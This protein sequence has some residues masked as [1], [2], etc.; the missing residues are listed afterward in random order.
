MKSLILALCLCLTGLLSAHHRYDAKI[1]VHSTID[2]GPCD[3]D[4]AERNVLIERKTVNGLEKIGLFTGSGCQFD[5]KT[6]LEAGDYVITFTGLAFET[7]QIDFI[8]N[9]TNYKHLV[10]GTVLLLSKTTQLNEVT[11][12]GNRRQFVKVESD[13]TTI[14]VRENG[15][16]NSGSSLDAVKKLPG[17]IKAPGGALSLNGK[18]VRIYID[19]SPSSLS[20]TDLENY[21][22]TLPANAIEKVELIYNPG[23]AYDANS[24]GSIINIVT[25]SKRM[26]GIN[27]SFNINYN[28]NRYQKPSPQ[29]LLNGREKDL[30]WQTMIGYN[31]IEGRNQNNTLQEFTYFTPVQVLDQRNLALFHWRNFYWRSGLNYKLNERSNLLLNYNLSTANDHIENQSSAFGPGVAYENNSM[32]KAK[33]AI[34]EVVL[35]YKVKLD[36]I[37][38][39]LDVTGF[40]NFFKRNPKSQATSLDNGDDTYNNSDID[41]RLENHYLKYDLAIPFRKIDFSIST[42][43]KYNILKVSNFGRYNFESDTDAIFGS[44]DF[45]DEIDFD[46]TEKNL[47]FY[48]EARKKFGKL[49]MTAGLRFEDFRV[50]RLASTVADRIEFNNTNFFPNLNLMYEITGKVKVSSSYSRKIQQPGYFTIDPNINNMFNKYTTSEGN[51]ALRPVFFDNFEFRVSAFEYVQAGFN[52]SR[53]SNNNQFMIEA[54]DGELLANRT[55]VAFDK[56][57]MFGAYL[58]FPIPLDYIFKG[59]A[60]F[61]ERMG[62]LDKMNYIMANIGWNKTVTEGYP[63]GYPN[64]GTFNFGTQ[65]QILLPWGITHN[66]SYFYLPKGVWEIYKITK[67]IQQFDISFNKEFMNK[68]LRLGL[69]VFDLFNVNEV[70]AYVTGRNLNTHFFEKQDSRTYRISLTWNFGNMKL[71]KDNTDINVEKANS[72]GGGL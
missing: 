68:K 43:G 4:K 35:Q 62:Q 48:L 10:V 1:E 61:E 34:H 55:F 15:L 45:E 67:P 71:E 14:S 22:A 54:E 63:L 39:T 12:Y 37:G 72:G 60:V 36:T 52:Y 27:A 49:N 56:M 16:L 17:V 65:A 30:S 69:H 24:S 46:Y 29:I 33:N 13:K 66:M 32:T 70:N 8:V 51:L 28:F 18:G 58:N 6:Q 23:A 11:I 19:G 7:Q 44:G 59:K 50:T 3:A 31:Y 21:L 42:G 40:T 20:G 25:S 2:G 5:I 57:E 41:F 64:K 26:K 53:A 47:A 9:E 38:R